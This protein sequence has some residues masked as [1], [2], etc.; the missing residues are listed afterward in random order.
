MT[1][2][3][4]LAVG[5]LESGAAGG[6]RFAP[7]H[8]QSRK[9]IAAQ[10]ELARKKIEE[11]Q[12]LERLGTEESRLLAVKKYEEGLQ[13]ARTAGNAAIEAVALSSLGLVYTSLGEKHK[14]LDSHTKALKLLRAIPYPEGE[15]RTLGWIGAVYFTLGENLKAIDSYTQGLRLARKL[16]RRDMEAD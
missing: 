1:F 8:A 15:V 10:R 6:T 9:S 11:G 16:G 4:L 7:T 13:L 2:V 3:L 12:S 14:A 5:M